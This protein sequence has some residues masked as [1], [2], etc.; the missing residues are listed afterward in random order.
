MKARF[1]LAFLVALGAA[2]GARALA[3]AEFCPA[4][5]GPAH[6]V[7]DGGGSL[8]S[9]TLNAEGPRS[10]TADVEVQT[11][12]GWYAFSIPTMAIV[13]QPV[14]YATSQVT[15]TRNE[16]SSAV[17]YV[18]FPGEAGKVLRWWVADAVS[19]GDA[20][21]GWDQKGKVQCPPYSPAFIPGAAPD[22]A[23][24]KR[25]QA[26][27]A[28]RVSPPAPDYDRMPSP[29]DVVLTATRAVAPSFSCAKPFSNSSVLHAVAPNWPLGYT[30]SVE[31]E[32]LV[33]VAVGA[34]GS[35]VDAWVFQPSGARAFDYAALDAARRST[36]AAGRA[37]C[38]PAPG[39]YLFRALFN[40]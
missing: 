32:T 10:I 34:D 17:F 23:V 2:C 15:F 39:T 28:Q 19:S 6:V 26:F 12:N 35:L 11:E 36:Y 4:R 8:F 25:Y 3:V 37:L 1:F 16:S 29:S 27:V 7:K 24:L 18:R 22:P 30:T 33:E 38:A 31:L 14:K 13:Q 40:P 5:I 9:T 20:L 21:M